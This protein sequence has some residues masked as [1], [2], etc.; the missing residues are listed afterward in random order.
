M[1]VSSSFVWNDAPLKAA[2]KRAGYIAG[3][4]VKEAAAARNPAP[5]RIR[6][7][8][9]YQGVGSGGSVLVVKGLGALAMIFE[10]G[11]QGGYAIQPGLK[12]I[13]GRVSGT[14]TA[15]GVRSSGGT[16]IRFTHGDGGFYRGAGFIGGPM[17]ER[18]YLRPAAALF[19][20]FYRMAAPLQ[21]AASGSATSSM[22]SGLLRAA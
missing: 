18:P 13:R 15:T 22:L 19:G 12:T 3:V 1:P 11:R 20:A 5:S 16:A 9:P 6:I 10:H 7:G 17:S 4:R 8:G 21:I 2:M 14:R